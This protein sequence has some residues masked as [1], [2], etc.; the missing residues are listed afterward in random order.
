MY[1]LLLI[2][3][4]P[5]LPYMYTGFESILMVAA[6]MAFT[7]ALFTKN[8]KVIR[9]TQLLCASPLQLIHNTVVMSMGGVICES[10]NMLSIIVS[11]FR[12]GSF[13][14]E[15]KGENH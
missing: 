10:F 7:G 13:A 4:I 11:L 8:S 15:S 6:Y 9:L 1:P 3:P 5:V 2:A 12:F 14:E